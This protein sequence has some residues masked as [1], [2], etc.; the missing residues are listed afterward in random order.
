MNALSRDLDAICHCASEAQALELHQ[1]LEQRFAEC[2]LRLHPQKTR[3]VY[4]KDAN[5]SGDFPDIAFDFLGF[6]FRARN[7]M[8]VKGNT[9]AK[10]SSSASIRRSCGMDFTMK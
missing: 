10:R 1:A 6:Q 4:C 9:R 8:W 5:R 3:V 2:R 7:T